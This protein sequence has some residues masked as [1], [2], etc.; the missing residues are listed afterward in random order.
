MHDFSQKF[1]IALFYTWMHVIAIF[2]VSEHFDAL[3]WNYAPSYACYFTKSSCGFIE[4]KFEQ[5]C[6]V[7]HD[8]KLM[9]LCLSNTDNES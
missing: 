9:G 2:E 1:F 6:T 4:K 8:E 3:L 7:N 5:Y